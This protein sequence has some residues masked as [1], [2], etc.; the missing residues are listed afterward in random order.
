M[1]FGPIDILVFV[2]FVVAVISIGIV[3]SRN[4]STSEDYFLAGRGLSWWLIGFSLIAANIST[5]QFVGMSGNAASHIGLAIASYEWMAAVT[6]VIVGFCFLP[7]FLRAGIYTMPEFLEYRYN[8]AARLIM[9]VATMFIYMLL[10]GAVTYSGALTIRTLAGKMGY[11]VSLLSGS[12]VIGVIAMVYVAAGGLKA[13]AWA[14]LIQGS[15]LILGGAVIMIFAFAALGNADEAAAVSDA[16]TGE[17][18]YKSFA[19]SQ[20]SIERFWELNKARMNMFLPRNDRTLP[21]T[22]LLLGLWIPNFYYWGLNQYITQRT[23]GS[24][25]LAQGQKGIVFSAFMKLLVPF[26]IVVPGIIAFNLYSKDMQLEAVHDNVAVMVKYYKAN[27]STD[28]LERIENPSNEQIQQWG[29]DR[30][31]IAVFDSEDVLAQTELNSPYILPLTKTDYEQITVDEYTVFKSDDQS[32]ASTYPILAGELGPYNMNV[33]ESAQT[34]GT[35]ISTEKFVAYKYDTAFAQLLGNVLPQNTGL[36]GFVLAALLG[37]VVSS[38]A[39]MLN[40]ASTIFSMDIFHKYIGKTAE[41]K[42]LVM[43]GRCCVVVFSLVAIALAPQL[44][45]PKI[46]NS[47]FTIIQESQG[48]ISP[49]ILAVFVFGLLIHRAPAFVGVVGLLTNI[50]AYGILKLYVPGLN[51]LNRMAI[52]LGLCLLIMAIMTVIKPLKEPIVFRQNTQ[53]ELTTSKTAKIFG[54]AIIII[55]LI[56]YIVFSPIGICK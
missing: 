8:S 36:V 3:K 7:Y 20:S 25:S 21:W 44:G 50:A 27:P 41:Q 54:V 45:N 46:S 22:A 38:L 42:T 40:A 12:V 15:A 32:W 10:L 34:G 9:A 37:A 49:G 48:F 17:V 56:F 30:M 29:S 14:D 26:V 13:C 4:E 19:Q 39:A 23:L 47:I 24:A 33:Q 5:E 6:L 18:V 55:T 53:I 16:G 11:D 31:M 43:V 1:I 28:F 35:G 2:V 52:C 51:F